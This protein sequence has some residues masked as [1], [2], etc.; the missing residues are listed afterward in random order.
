MPS[1]QNSYEQRSVPQVL[2]CL[3]SADCEEGEKRGLFFLFG[4]LMFIL[5]SFL[6]LFMLRCPISGAIMFA[7]AHFRRERFEPGR[8]DGAGS[9]GACPPQAA[10]PLV[11][12]VRSP[13]TWALARPTGAGRDCCC[14]AAADAKLLRVLKR[15][16]FHDS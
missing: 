8:S 7:S 6:F 11:C 13:S 16:C 15:D 10:A 12:C 2:T 5:F 3:I 14:Q 9:P 4:L 1:L